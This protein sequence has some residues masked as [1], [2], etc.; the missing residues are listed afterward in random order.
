MLERA[1]RRAAERSIDVG[2]VRKLMMKVVYRFCNYKGI[3]RALV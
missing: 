1:G 2:L 3:Q